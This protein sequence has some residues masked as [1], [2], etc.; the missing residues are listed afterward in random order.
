MIMER[1]DIIVQMH[2][3]IEKLNKILAEKTA[4]EEALEDKT[5]GAE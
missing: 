2:E 3:T 1:N 4:R 5:M